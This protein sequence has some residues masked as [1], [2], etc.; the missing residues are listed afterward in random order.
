MDLYHIIA[1]GG[2]GGSGPIAQLST[3]GGIVYLTMFGVH[4]AHV[5]I[6]IFRDH[7]S[8]RDAVVE[9]LESYEEEERHPA[10]PPRSRGEGSG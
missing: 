4:V 5:V 8:V 7:R 10:P 6:V 9:E 3:A 2:G 1:A